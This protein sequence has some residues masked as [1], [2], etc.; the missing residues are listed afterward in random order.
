MLDDV[1]DYDFWPHAMLPAW[2]V[3]DH[4]LVIRKTNKLADELVNTFD[5]KDCSNRR[6][7][8]IDADGSLNSE[9]ESLL[10]CI[11]DPDYQNNLDYLRATREILQEHLAILLEFN[12]SGVR[13]RPEYLITK[14]Q[15]VP[16]REGVKPYVYSLA[17]GD[18]ELRIGV[19]V[20]PPQ[21]LKLIR[22][23][24]VEYAN[25]EYIDVVMAYR[26]RAEWTQDS[27]R[28]LKNASFHGVQP[29][30]HDA[31]ERHRMWEKS[32]EED[33][34][35]IT[36]FLSHALKTP[37]ANTQSILS[38]IKLP[39]LDP[40]VREEKI[41]EL[42]SLVTDV[43]H[44]VELLLFI[45]TTEE[46]ITAPVRM[47]AADDD[48]PWARFGIKD[49][50]SVVAS[51][52]QSVHNRRTRN[53]TDVEKIEALFVNNALPVP[54]RDVDGVGLTAYRNLARAIISIEAIDPRQVFAIIPF[55]ES[56][57]L[58]SIKLSEQA[59]TVLLNLLLV[60]LIVNAVK[61]ADEAAPL[62]TV[63]LRLSN[64]SDRLE[65]CVFNNGTELNPEIERVGIETKVHG[66]KR[67]MLGRLLNQ[68][69][70]KALRWELKVLP[71]P[72]KGTLFVIGLP[73]ES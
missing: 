25:V 13:Q 35:K 21:G 9:A 56:G 60:E 57:N 59:K 65:I 6:F 55:V 27:P 24:D 32:K 31:T 72:A 16:E 43:S 50:E 40:A 38:S 22:A 61:N 73:I 2:F 8:P 1:D 28:L 19:K 23:A 11:V 29:A 17:P 37:L 66:E 10:Y 52:L 45:N 46:D 18:T 58:E 69:A 54:S 41:L 4:Q 71:P 62:I 39:G 49:V 7:L 67:K 48:T 12:N 44:L 20:S 53:Q 14:L 47:V 34:A 3:T 64:R 36:Q 30:I 42:E 33:E 70:A 68:K 51:A 15:A 26:V 5:V 63:K